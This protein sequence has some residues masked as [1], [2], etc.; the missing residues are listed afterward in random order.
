[1]SI[2][3][4]GFVLRVSGVTRWLIWWT[5]TA[6]LLLPCSSSLTGLVPV[7]AAEATP[8]PRADRLS[9]PPLPT[10]PSQVD[11]GAQVYYQVCMACHGDLGQGLTDEWREA[12]GAD[13]NCWESKCHGPNHPPHGFSFPRITRAVIGPG[14]L[15]RF[16]NAEELHD[17]IAKTMPWWNPGG[18]TDEEFWQVTAFL[19]KENYALPPHV[20]LDANNGKAFPVHP[21]SPPHETSLT[22]GLLLA[23][24]LSS[25]AIFFAL[26]HRS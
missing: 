12:W 23:A 19:M 3:R 9:A 5:M 4:G 13:S 18:L 26:Q 1:M 24:G 22:P 11:R 10:N 21:V 7:Q 6:S 14:T 8:T 2:L 16:R 15:A 17:Y 20:V 25:A